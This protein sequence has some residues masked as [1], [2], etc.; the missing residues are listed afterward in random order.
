MN[1]CR[2]LACC[3]RCHVAH[4]LSVECVDALIAD[5][6][7]LRATLVHIRLD[8]EDVNTPRAARA[9]LTNIRLRAVRALVTR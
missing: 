5:A 9:A 8:T 7:R 1:A 2:E 4:H 3:D 6:E